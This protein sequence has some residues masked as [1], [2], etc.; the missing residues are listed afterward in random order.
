[1]FA[2]TKKPPP[3]P[4][5]LTAWE[6]EQVQFSMFVLGRLLT[7]P[8]A[9]L[10][11]RARPDDL[12][13][14][15]TL[16]RAVMRQHSKA[17]LASV[18]GYTGDRSAVVTS[19]QILKRALDALQAT[20]APQSPQ[21]MLEQVLA[22]QAPANHGIIALHTSVALEELG[23]AV[24]FV[25]QS[26][27]EEK[28]MVH[29]RRLSRLE[30]R[31]LLVERVLDYLGEIDG[32]LW[33]PLDK[34]AA[35]WWFARHAL[36]YA[37]G[38]AR[39]AMA[40]RRRECVLVESVIPSNDGPS[41]TRVEV[42]VS[43]TKNGSAELVTVSRRMLHSVCGVFVVRA[44]KGDRAMLEHIATGETFRVHTFEH[45]KGLITGDPVIF[46]RLVPVGDEGAD[47]WVLMRSGWSLRGLSADRIDG[48][49]RSFVRLREASMTPGV[50]TEMLLSSQLSD[51]PLPRAEPAAESVDEARGLLEA[52]TRWRQASSEPP[53]PRTLWLA[54]L[55]GM[56]READG[57]TP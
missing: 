6:M 16:T 24:D 47:A 38:E 7:L 53:E 43:L 41:I 5:L 4:R 57:S 3:S 2:R 36:D 35:L 56:V 48:M 28:V 54:A 15:A 40:H 14:M 20:L 39:T 13:R 51:E 25:R 21:Q 11:A 31:S 12:S 19:R 42:V 18:F 32:A 44:V 37:A 9:G 34:Q 1:M 10:A 23:T 33:E 26:A 27:V 45:T 55:E 49:R 17:L 8:G 30:A 52:A 22:Q 29:W 50:I 46:G